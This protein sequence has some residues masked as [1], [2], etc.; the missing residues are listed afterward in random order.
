MKIT[1]RVKAVL[2]ALM[3]I[4]LSG[5][6]SSEQ[7]APKLEQPSVVNV[8]KSSDILD[9]IENTPP[10]QPL[11]FDQELDKV[12]DYFMGLKICESSPSID[13][14]IQASE[15]LEN[16]KIIDSYMTHPNVGWF[17]NPHRLLWKTKT[18]NQGSFTLISRNHWFNEDI[19]TII[20]GQYLDHLKSEGLIDKKE[21][22]SG[23]VNEYRFKLT[24][25]LSISDEKIEELMRVDN[26]EKYKFE[27]MS[28]SENPWEGM[29][30]KEKY[31]EKPWDY[32]LTNYKDKA[33]VRYEALFVSF[34]FT[35][36]SDWLRKQLQ[37]RDQAYFRIC[38]DSIPYGTNVKMFR[39]D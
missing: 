19:N 37:S 33:C 30:D 21:V 9:L 6:G 18:F 2:S 8:N 23:A 36:N 10:D 1:N 22:T 31:S 38:A 32:V 29:V 4:G 24:E 28:Y 26:S 12:Y 39:L 3:V 13:C 14:P 20:L 17:N 35:Y 34:K 7:N 5:C 15:H 11:I 25:P 16:F 27:F